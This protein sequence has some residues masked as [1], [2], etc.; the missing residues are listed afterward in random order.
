MW[1]RRS[2]TTLRATETAN[3]L[4]ATPEV[5]A[6]GK[7]IYQQNCVTCHGD[8]GRGDG[9]AA[10]SLP[11]LPADFTQQHFAMHTDAEVFG[12]IKGGKPGTV[13]PAFGDALDD[14]QVWQVITYIRQF[15]QGVGAA[16]QP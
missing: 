4:T 6:S 1:R 10:R 13:M 5:L 11:G 12:W 7:R 16:Q 8:T 14:E 9:A 2:R 3:P 15:A